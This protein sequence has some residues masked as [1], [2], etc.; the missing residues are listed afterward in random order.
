MN[1][2]DF[3]GDPADREL[4]ERLLAERDGPPD[5]ALAERDPDYEVRSDPDPDAAR[6]LAELVEAAAPRRRRGH[7]SMTAK[8]EPQAAPINRTRPVPGAEWCHACDSWCLPSGI[9]GCNSR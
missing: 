4:Y 8:H 5:K 9:C 7:S 1:A 6:H 2:E 3:N